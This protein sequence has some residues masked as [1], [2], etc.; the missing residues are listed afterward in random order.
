MIA[1]AATRTERLSKY[2]GAGLLGFIT[3]AA[4]AFMSS[5]LVITLAALLAFLYLLARATDVPRLRLVG[6][7][8]LAADVA[9][10]LFVAQLWS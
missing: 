8:L 5:G 4:V 3:G 10:A 1:R 2:L 6:L 7:Y 9:F